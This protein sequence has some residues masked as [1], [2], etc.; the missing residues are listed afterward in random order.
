MCPLDPCGPKP[1]KRDEQKCQAAPEDEGK[2]K[3][4][5]RL[6]RSRR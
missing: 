6:S 1:A 4:R 3:A 2:E 5:K